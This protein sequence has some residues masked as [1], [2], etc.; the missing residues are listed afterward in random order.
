MAACRGFARFVNVR[1]EHG[2][3]ATPL[4]LAARQGRPQCVHH[5]LHAG[6][7]VSA[8]TASYGFPGSTALHLAA[9]RGNLDCVRELLAWGADRFHRDS[10]GRIAYAVALRR[11]H[12]ACAALLN[13]AAAEP[14]V[15][16]SPLKFISE[17]N[18][19][20]GGQGPDGSQQGAGEADH[21]QPQG[22]H[23]NQNRLLLVV[24]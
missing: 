4:H 6:A 11:S 17:L 21:C 8:P 1:D 13:P 9:R 24:C 5:L 10:A 14:M 19:E 2:A 3:T 15:W 7:I 22:G 16:P 18:P 12:R 23:H 20:G